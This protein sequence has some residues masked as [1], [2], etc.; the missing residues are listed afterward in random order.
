MEQ[1]ESSKVTKV[2]FK[3]ISLAQVINAI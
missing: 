2:T 3:V 1:T